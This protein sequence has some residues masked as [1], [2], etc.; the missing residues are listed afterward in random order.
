[1]KSQI[2]VAV[3][4]SDLV[5]VYDFIPGGAERPIRAFQAI[6]DFRYEAIV[7]REAQEE[8]TPYL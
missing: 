5:E 2:V 8:D 3:V 7:N 1:L 4:P 6:V